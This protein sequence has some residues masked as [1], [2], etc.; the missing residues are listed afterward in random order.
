[1]MPFQITK[2]K[3]LFFLLEQSQVTL[4]LHSHP[5][6][7]G[8]F[9]SCFTGKETKLGQVTRL[10]NWPDTIQAG[11]CQRCHSNL[12]P[13]LQSISYLPWYWSLGTQNFMVFQVNLNITELY[14]LHLHSIPQLNYKQLLQNRLLSFHYICSRRAIGQVDC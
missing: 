12:G 9:Y 8:F 7:Q 13:F 14:L 2:L 6:N 11:K 5:I 3:I 10:P 4:N 1:M